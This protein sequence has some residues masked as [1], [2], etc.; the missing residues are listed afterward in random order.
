M[1]T[2]SR[3]QRHSI[4]IDNDILV[5]IKSMVYEHEHTFSDTTKHILNSIQQS[6]PFVSASLIDDNTNSQLRLD[7]Y[8]Y[9]DAVVG[10]LLYLTASN[11]G[12]R[13]TRRV[14]MN[15]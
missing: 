13:L 9:Q 11:K 1:K 12:S 6:F 14:Y 2:H 10:L 5:V 4:I 8:L 3:I 15:L 7:C